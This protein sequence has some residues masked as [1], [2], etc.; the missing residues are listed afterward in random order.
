MHMEVVILVEEIVYVVGRE[1][2]VHAAEV[3]ID[4]LIGWVK[5]VEDL[6]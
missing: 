2:K 5:E 3:G 1:V 4:S 6:I